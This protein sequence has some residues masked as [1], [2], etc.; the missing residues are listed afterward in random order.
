MK[1]FFPFLAFVLLLGSAMAAEAPTSV[2]EL[3]G[4]P[5][6]LQLVRQPDLVDVCILHHIPP[7]TRADGSIDRSVER[8]EDTTFVPVPAETAAV[9]RDLLL[10]EKTYDW[11]AGS[12]GR[13]PQFYLRLRFHRGNEFLAIDFCFM[14]NVLNVT[15]RGEELGH[16]NFGRNTDLFLQAFLKVFP[17]DEPLLGVAREVGLPR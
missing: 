4:T 16:A 3:F 15:R 14:C 17:H 2:A 8:Y 7:G 11:P 9:L 12:G 10:S 5:E 13:R 1:L 6:N